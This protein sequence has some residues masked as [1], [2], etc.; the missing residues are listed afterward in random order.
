MEVNVRPLRMPPLLQAASARGTRWRS[1]MRGIQSEVNWLSF[2]SDDVRATATKLVLAVYFLCSI[3][4]MECALSFLSGLRMLVV[5]CISPPLCASVAAA[6]ARARPPPPAALTSFP[7]FLPQFTCAGYAG[8]H[9]WR[10][11]GRAPVHG[12]RVRSWMRPTP[13][14]STPCTLR[15]AA[16]P[17]WPPS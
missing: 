9:A 11:G 7:L 8:D 10:V 4:I 13:E 16:Q 17:T 2:K 5:V 3:V 14:L 15:P 1:V 12:G 6:R